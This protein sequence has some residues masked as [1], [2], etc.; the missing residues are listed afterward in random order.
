[1]TGD[2]QVGDVF[3]G[4]YNH[5]DLTVEG[6]TTATVFVATDEYHFEYERK[7]IAARYALIDG[8]KLDRTEEPYDFRVVEGIFVDDVTENRCQDRITSWSRW[9]AAM[10]SSKR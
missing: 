7:R 9:S 2:L 8:E 1:M 6:Q 10:P 4:D 3:R 5:G